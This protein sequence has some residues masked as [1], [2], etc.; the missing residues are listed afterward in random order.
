MLPIRPICVCPAP[1]QGPQE[2][3]LS[4]YMKKDKLF[5]KNNTQI[6]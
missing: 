4:V 3:Y 5:Y 6:V 1:S 2:P